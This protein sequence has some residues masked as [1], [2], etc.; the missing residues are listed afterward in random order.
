MKLLVKLPHI[1]DVALFCSAC[2]KFSEPITY[3]IGNKTVNAKSINGM[4]SL[5]VNKMAYVEIDTE[6][7]R[8]IDEFISHIN[9]WI[10]GEY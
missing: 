10:I 3:T 8:I 7:P 4:L 1:H 9:L 2:S 6:N 5:T